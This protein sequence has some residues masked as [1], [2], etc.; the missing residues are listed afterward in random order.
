MTRELALE[1][2]NLYNRLLQQAQAEFDEFRYTKLTRLMDLSLDRYAR[3]Y[4]KI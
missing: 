4:G 2:Y 3:R 1:A